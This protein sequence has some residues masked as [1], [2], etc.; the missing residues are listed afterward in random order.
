M[1]ALRLAGLA[2]LG[3]L[4]LSIPALRAQRIAPN[5][6]F[7]A[8]VVKPNPEGAPMVHTFSGVNLP[9]SPPPLCRGIDSRPYPNVPLNRCVS[10]G[11]T[12]KWLIA[13]AYQVRWEQIDTLIIGGPNWLDSDGFDVEAKAESPATEAQLHSMLRALLADRFKLKLHRE[14]KEMR[15]LAMTVAKGGPKLVPSPGDRNCSDDFRAC[16]MGSG[17]SFRGKSQTMETLANSLSAWI[18]HV[19]V[20][21]TGLKGLYDFDTGPWRPENAGDNFSAEVGASPDTTPTIFTALQEKLGLRLESQKAK[22][23]VFVIDSAEKPQ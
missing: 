11:H 12:L 13:A 7:E 20:D 17:A 21:K 3:L 1:K 16:G 18:G 8:A 15:V 4:T 6:S 14:K 2:T 10:R 19:V 9:V 23:E 22:V 5:A